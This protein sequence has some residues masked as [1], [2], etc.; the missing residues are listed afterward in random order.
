MNQIRV[1]THRLGTTALVDVDTVIES[2]AEKGG[3]IGVR[4]QRGHP[5]FGFVDVLRIAGVL[6]RVQQDHSGALF[7]EVIYGRGGVGN[8]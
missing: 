6:Q 7:H 8:M 1:T 4:I 2:D 3:V 5:T